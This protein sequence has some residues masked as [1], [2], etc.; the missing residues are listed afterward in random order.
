M[1]CYNPLVAEE[2]RQKRE[3]LLLATERELAKIEARVRRR[4]RKPLTADE[5]GVAV[6]KVLRRWKVGK[7]FQLEIRDGHFAFRRKKASIAREAEL[8]GFY[9]L[10]TNVPADRMDAPK[11]QAT[12][13]HDPPSRPFLKV[14]LQVH[15]EAARAPRVAR[16]AFP[17]DD[18]GRSRMRPTRSASQAI[19][20]AVG[21]GTAFWSSTDS[22]AA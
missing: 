12:Y 5:I 10:R 22:L 13:T 7:H 9:V 20:C 3:A 11:V 4:R 2:R 1:V 16:L 21:Y 19:T 18:A 14:S 15:A 6:G 17:P 8:D